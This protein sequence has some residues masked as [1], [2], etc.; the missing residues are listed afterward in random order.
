[1]RIRIWQ[2]VAEAAMVRG[3]Q[4]E[5]EAARC[6]DKAPEP[7][8]VLDR[9]AGGAALAGRKEAAAMPVWCREPGGILASHGEEEAVPP[10]WARD[11]SPRGSPVALQEVAAETDREAD[12][13][14]ILHS[15]PGRF[16]TR[17]VSR[18][19]EAWEA[20]RIL[21]MAKPSLD[22]VPAVRDR[23]AVPA[24]AVTGRETL[25]CRISSR[26]TAA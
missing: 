12:Q 7:A 18:A 21:R 17:I 9:E 10:A 22:R 11:L 3:R 6:W 23:E 5:A 13:E 15:S 4:R 20:A 19:L 14:T 1:M 16:Q 8:P 2:K 24:E 25:S 26:P